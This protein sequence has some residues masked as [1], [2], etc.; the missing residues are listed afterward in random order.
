MDKLVMNY[1]VTEGLQEAAA[2]FEKESGATPTVDLGTVQVRVRIRD[3]V[4][5][6]DLQGA[7]EG[8]QRMDPLFLKE[9]GDLHYTLR[10]Q[11]FIELVRRKE[12]ADALVLART[13]LV[14]I[15]E[16]RPELLDDL[17]NAVSILAFVDCPEKPPAH[18]SILELSHLHDIASDINNEILALD[19]KDMKSRPVTLE[20]LVLM[21][22]ETE[23]EVEK[24][25]DFPMATDSEDLVMMDANP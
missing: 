19:C 7:I 1:L 3:S 12:T 2:A 20:G 21:L 5:E 8:L 25:I 6:G 4:L 11:Q 17:E 14:P 16:S 13:E 22:M 9:R 10:R 23:R 18:T 15:V 24:K